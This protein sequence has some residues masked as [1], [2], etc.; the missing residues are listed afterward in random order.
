MTSHPIPNSSPGEEQVGLVLELEVEVGNVVLL[1]T[2]LL[3]AVTGTAAGPGGQA[4]AKSPWE[5][6]LGM[7]NFFWS[8]QGFILGFFLMIKMIRREVSRPAA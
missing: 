8:K 7:L 6:F 4:G 2:L 3:L 5:F 1:G